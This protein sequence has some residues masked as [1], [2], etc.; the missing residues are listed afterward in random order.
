MHL[1]SLHTTTL[2]PA[3]RGTIIAST[4]G[5]FITRNI[6]D[7]LKHFA[8]LNIPADTVRG[9]ALH[10]QQE[11]KKWDEPLALELEA[12]AAELDIELWR[13]AA[14]NA[15]TEVL[16]AAPPSKE[17]ECSTAVF[18]P[19][20]GAPA[21]FQTWDWHPHL[22]ADGL[23][24]ELVCRDG[25]S[26]KLFTEFGINGKIGV[27]SHGLGVHFNILAHAQDNTSGGVPVHSIAR[28]VLERASSIDQAVELTEGVTVS[29][30]TVLT[31]IQGGE[32]PEVA[33]IEFS[34]S[35]RRIVNR[36]ISGWALHT[37]HFLDAQLFAGDVMPADSTTAE[38]YAYLDERTAGAEPGSTQ[39]VIDILAS[40]EGQA[41]VLCM[42]PEAGKPATEQ[43]ET[44]LSVGIDTENI[45]LH[46]LNGNPDSAA[47]TGLK[48]F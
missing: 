42:A 22:A 37:N 15:R 47:R 34:P 29:A 19:A 4:F 21:T 27:N 43:W 9:I 30:S 17:G 12:Q 32:H 18:V 28:S 7:Y 11:L 23:L 25:R 38:R 31:V 46:Y 40:P 1:H 6:D 3:E 39:E 20:Q 13:L 14:L 35:G 5:P 36:T 48:I 2:D 44:L 8:S 45:A 41:P 33:S 24:H 10:S 26:V 16:A